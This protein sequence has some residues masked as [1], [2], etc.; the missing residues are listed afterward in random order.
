[1][2]ISHFKAAREENWEKSEQALELIRRAQDEGLEVSADLYPYLAGSTSLVTM[3]PE[4]AH[5]GGPEETLK[6]LAD[7]ETRV[8]MTSDMQAGGFAK[9]FDWSQVLITSAPSQTEYEGRYVSDLAA[10]A[11]QLPYEWVFDALQQSRL[12]ISMAIFGMSEEN[13]RRELA[14]A[15]M[16]I[17]TDGLG[18]AI[19]GP[20][21][22]GVPH[23]RNYGAFPR[24]LSR[25]VREL[26]IL[27]LE[28]AVYRMSGLPARKLR[29]D[30]RGRIEKDRAADLV[31]FDPATITDKADYENPHQYAAGIFEVIVNGNFVIRD[32]QHTG[33]LAGKILTR[34]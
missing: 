7:P 15:G 21:A 32:G 5:V 3:L 34:G 31:V 4:W 13:R 26:N 17:G 29:L 33:K 27:T 14:F 9:G 23:P 22:K 25:Y 30:D 1:M 20:M 18:L 10:E 8:K 11:G 16:M 24:V 2:Q 28:E 19:S 6:R 12:D